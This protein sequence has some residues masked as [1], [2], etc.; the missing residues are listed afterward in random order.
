MIDGHTKL[1]GLIGWPVDHSLSFKMQNA[2][3]AALKLNWRYLPLPVEPSR[4]AEA[5]YGLRALGFYGA[6]VTAPHK[7]SVIPFV[8]RLSPEARKIGAVNTIT[9]EGQRYLVGHNTDSI[10]FID[11]LRGNGFDPKQKQATVVGAG[12]AARAAVYALIASEAKSITILSRNPAQADELALFFGDSRLQTGILSRH[13]IIS[14]AEGSDLLVNA[15]PVG[16]LAH[17]DCSIWPDDVPI[18]SHVTVLDLVYNPR[19]TRLL[20]QALDA[21][22]KAI[23][24]L[25]MLLFQGA[26]SFA[27]WTEGK[28]PIEAM[29]KALEEES[30]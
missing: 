27:L 18:P 1:S 25:E 10:G 16:M 14:S 11:C 8:D 5:I 19:N 28:P 2:A 4:I 6:N 21:G 29:R 17:V 26:A 3:F 12:G 30:S 13:E 24:G 7:Q 15:T 9:V 23:S 22:A 20:H